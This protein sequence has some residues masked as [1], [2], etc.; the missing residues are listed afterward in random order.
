[1][2]HGKKISKKLLFDQK[3][4]FLLKKMIYKAFRCLFFSFIMG[5]TLFCSIHFIV[6]LTK[7]EKI[8]LLCVFAKKLLFIIFERCIYKI[9]CFFAKPAVFSVFYLF[10]ISFFVVF[11]YCFWNIANLAFYSIKMLFLNWF[12]LLGWFMQRFLRF[13]VF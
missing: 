3:S 12:L 5:F 2:K 6:F 9:C 11:S 13:C 8:S 4:D 7:I 10:Y 1:M